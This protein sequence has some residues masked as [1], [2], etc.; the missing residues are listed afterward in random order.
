MANENDFRELKVAGGSY[1]L[2]QILRGKPGYERQAAQRVFS[3][4]IRSYPGD[5]HRLWWKW[6]IEASNSLEL[7]CKT[8]DCTV[9]QAFHLA[10]D[11]GQLILYRDD[12]D[13]QWL[14]VLSTQGN[15]FQVVRA[16]NGQQQQKRMRTRPLR[17]LLEKYADQG[18]VRCV[19]VHPHARI[20]TQERSQGPPTPFQRLMMLLRPEWSDIWVVL[21]FAF[22][23]GLLMLATPLAVETL[24]NTV[25][26]GRYVQPIMV[27]AIIL[28]TFL[29]FQAAIR[30][31]QTY[32]VEIIQRRMFARV[33]ADLAFRLPRT[34]AEA[35]DG[36]HMPELVN[37][38]FDVVS[39]QKISAFFLLD[40]V[41]LVLSTFI[42]MAVLG[43][44]HPW[45]LGF[46][47]MLLAAI[48]FI[49]FVLGRGAIKSAIKESKHKYYMAAWLED[50]AGCPVAFRSC[51]GREF[52]LDRADRLIHQYLT[53]RRDHFHI[54]MRQIVFALGL[55]AVASTILLGL[56]GWLVVSG[57]LTLGQLVAAELIVSAIVGAFAK[58][59]KHME[60]F[61]DLLAS[62]DKLG[63]L[64]DLST[65]PTDGVL[66]ADAADNPET[67]AATVEFHG[68]GYAWPGQR[69]A[70]FGAVSMTVA[71]GTTVALFGESG[72]GKSTIVDLCYGLREPTVGHVTINGFDPR[73]VRLDRLRSQI[74][75]A[76]GTE[77]FHAT[78]EEN[79]HMH[80]SDVSATD[81]RQ[82]LNELGVLDQVLRLEHGCSTELATGGAP[83]TENVCRLIVLARAVA[84]NPRLLLVDGL[85]DSLSDDEAERALDYLTRPERPWTLIVATGRKTIAQRCE[86]VH[87]LSAGSPA[88]S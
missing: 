10:R 60:S 80:R 3:E 39:V 29:G 82:V 72:S 73:D 13:P 16:G 35:T 75:L 5:V 58:L 8:L 71:A 49:I 54:L 36:K 33:A 81:V 85:L 28:L 45:L 31:L 25:A 51:G 61:Y 4:V 41:S 70:F 34:E 15:R 77:V 42:G 86:Q 63:V 2:D 62:V 11:G 37:R 38:F 66:S 1:V 24:V 46:D 76:R 50:I 69:Q 65:E 9:D 7:R 19:I 30:A 14:A 21:V 40:G 32:V 88:N 52:A 56:G 67:E 43:F 79:V 78:V 48:A 12:L 57:E 26:F 27:L 83:L 18:M 20:H 84:S 23:V 87:P 74:G 17:K 68:V 47:L 55:Q 44:Y 22:V 64:M 6:F 53:A 59:G